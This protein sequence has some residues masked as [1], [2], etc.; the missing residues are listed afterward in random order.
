MGDM[1]SNGKI[2]RTLLGSMK[3]PGSNLSAATR[4]YTGTSANLEQRW[5]GL[6]LL[7]VGLQG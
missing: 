1:S 3:P 4:R 7:R 2:I 6:S 5:S